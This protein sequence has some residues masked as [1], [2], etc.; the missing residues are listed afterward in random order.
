M[1]EYCVTG[2]TRFIA[3]YLVKSL[4]EKGCY[5]R[6]TVRDP[7]ESQS[8]VS[9]LSLYL[10]QR[11]RYIC[12]STAENV[13]KVGFLWEMKGAN[14]RLKVFKADLTEEGSF[15]E[16]IQGVHGVFHTASSVLVPYD[17]NVQAN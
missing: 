8:Q 2:G 16:A 14:E 5:V 6:T 15:D 10:S 11:L 1:E 7:G 17:S 12:M 9:L 3:A 4:L 13:E